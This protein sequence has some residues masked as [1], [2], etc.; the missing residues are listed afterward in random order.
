MKAIIERLD[1]VL[2]VILLIIIS[3]VLLC[4]MFAFPIWFIVWALTGWNYYDVVIGGLAEKIFP[5]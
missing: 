4:L 2:A 5:T 1:H 3:I